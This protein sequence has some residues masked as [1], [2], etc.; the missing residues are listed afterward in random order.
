MNS[1]LDA[2]RTYFSQYNREVIIALGV[3]AA[4]VAGVYFYADYRQQRIQ[5]AQF[6]FAQCYQHYKQ[7]QTGKDADWSE[8]EFLS[9][10][11]YKQHAATQIG[12][13]FKAL[14]SEAQF[15]QGKTADALATLESL[16]NVL[17]AKNPFYYIYAMKLALMR[18]ATNDE[19][20]KDQGMASL[21]AL[22]A[23]QNNKQRDEALYYLGLHYAQRGE[24]EKSRQAWDALVEEFGKASVFTSPWVSIIQGKLA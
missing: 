11:G 12:R 18:L 10:A 17:D 6:D 15:E 3:C 16:V 14:E 24:A 5:A 8:V 23:D 1:S 20:Q 7:A 19:A 9:A 21:Q 13:Y 2:V 22:A 4:G